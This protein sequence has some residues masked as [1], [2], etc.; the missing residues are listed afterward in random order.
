MITL[1]Q[2]SPKNYLADMPAPV[3]EFK[4]ELEYK[5][6]ITRFNP[7]EVSTIF[8]RKTNKWTGTDGIGLRI[9]KKTADCLAKPLARIFQCSLQEDYVQPHWRVANV[10]PIFRN[11]SKTFPA[12]YHPVSYT[13]QISKLVESMIRDAIVDHLRHHNLLRLSQ[14]GF[15]RRRIFLSLVRSPGPCVELCVHYQ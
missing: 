4:G 3:Q 7:E 11:A 12:N 9:L 8:K 2:C 5:L 10:N 14:Y 15:L 13:S 6:V 1:H